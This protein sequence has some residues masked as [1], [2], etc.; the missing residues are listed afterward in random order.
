MQML[1]VFQ[2]TFE[3]LHH[4][5]KVG[6][7]NWDVMVTRYFDTIEQQD[8]LNKADQFMSEVNTWCTSVHTWLFQLSASYSDRQQHSC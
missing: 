8:I 7:M 2:K 1:F 6:T 4:E 3:K 5:V